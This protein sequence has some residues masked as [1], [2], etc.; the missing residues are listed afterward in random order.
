MPA[1]NSKNG[2]VIRLG[3]ATGKCNLLVL[4]AEQRRNLGARS[5]KRP[6]CRLP[7]MVDTGGVAK[8]LNQQ[9]RMHFEYL[10]RY[11]RCRVVIKVET[12]HGV[13]STSVVRR[14]PL[15]D[16]RGSVLS[17]RAAGL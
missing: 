11:R 17:T 1:A 4:A 10:R 2:K 9:P 15:A 16:A 7:M 8:N 13:D 14:Q 12:A 3:A 5:V 6:P